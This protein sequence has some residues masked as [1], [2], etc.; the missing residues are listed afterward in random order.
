MNDSAKDPR[1]ET[2]QVDS[3]QAAKEQAKD[4]F[5]EIIGY[6]FL[7]P[8]HL[9]RG[10]GSMYL[11]GICLLVAI[12]FFIKHPLVLVLLVASLI[13]GYLVLNKKL[14][15]IYREKNK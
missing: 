4:I 9:V 8:V 6:L 3:T 12:A 14:E 1:D 5:S 13:R 10:R 2:E 15:N 7:I 11:P